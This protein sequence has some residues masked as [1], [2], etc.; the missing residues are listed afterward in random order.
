MYNEGSREKFLTLNQHNERLI[1]L[2]RGIE[3]LS[4][5]DNRRDKIVFIL[6][7]SAL[8]LDNKVPTGV[9]F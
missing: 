4:I 7:L 9:H 3:G 2:L 5:E 6:P 1:N 8:A